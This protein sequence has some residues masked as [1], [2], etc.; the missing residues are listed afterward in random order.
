MSFPPSVIPSLHSFLTSIPPSDK[1][2]EAQRGNIEKHSES[3]PAFLSLP[4]ADSEPVAQVYL[5]NRREKGGSRKDKR[6]R[7]IQKIDE[8]Y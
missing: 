1:G 3:L 4:V 6:S 7:Q 2:E 8:P 5:S